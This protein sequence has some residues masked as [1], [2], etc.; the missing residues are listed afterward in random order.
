MA[1]KHFVILGLGTFGV[2]LA[3]RFAQNGCRVTGVDGDRDRVEAIKDILYE[4][5]I[6]DVTDRNTLAQ[7]S[8]ENVD[9][10]FI[11]LGDDITP[12]LLATLH[13]KELKARRV[14]VK[15]VTQDHAKILQRLGVE[16]A[17]FPEVEIA[18]S[19]ADRMTWPN[20]LDYLPIDPTHSV[21]EFAPPASLV[22]HTLRELDFRRRFGVW[23]LGIKDAMTGN[24]T[25]FPDADFRVEEDQVLVV[26]GSQSGLDGLRKLP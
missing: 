7:L 22:G 20:V 14:I 12:S 2:P 6:A 15:A 4:A 18:E 19:L 11:S 10:V 24:L 25:V 3:R 9:A 1:I 13:A 8:L 26:L 5:V 21:V 17:V 23:V 16:R